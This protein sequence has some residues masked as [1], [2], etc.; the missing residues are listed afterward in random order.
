VNGVYT[1][2]N[3]EEIESV[4]W[5]IQVTDTDANYLP[6]FTSITYNVQEGSAINIPYKPAGDTAS[7]NITNIPSG[8]ANDGFNIVGTA[9][10]ITNGYGQAVQHVL[11]VTKANS[12][13]SV[14][15]T[16]TINVKANLAGN[17]FTLIDK[18]NGTIKFTQDGGATEL[19]FN[20][21]TFNA[22][23]TYKFYLDHYSIESSDGLSVVDSSGNILTG[24]EGLSNSGNSGDAGAY[25]QYVIPSNVAPGK[26][27]RYYDNDTSANYTDIP[28]TL[29]GST[30][31]ANPT[32]ITLEGPSANQTG[33]NVMDQY[34]HGWISLNETLA[35]GERLVLD[36]AFF[37]DFFGEFM[38]NN[39]IFAIGLKGD[40]WTNTKEVNN[41]TAAISGE[42]FKG[43]AYIIGVCTSGG[44]QVNMAIVANGQQGNTMVLNS[45][46]LRETTC[47]FLEVTGSGNNIRAAFGRN[48]SN[49]VTSGSESTVRYGDW[50]SYKGQT[51]EQG[52]GI[53]N[54]DV[55]MSFWT[56]DGGDIDGNE[57]DWTGLTEI[58][59]PAAPTSSSTNFTKA[60]DFSSSTSAY[61][62]FQGSDS[63]W[64]LLKLPA[65]TV[66]AHSSDA[67]L[68]SNASAA[69]PFLTSCVFQ[70]G[71][72]GPSDNYGDQSGGRIWWAGQGGSIAHHNIMLEQKGNDIFFSWGKVMA[73]WPN[74]TQENQIRVIENADPTKW[75]GV[76]IA[77]R[78]HRSSSPSAADLGAMFD[79]YVMS[80]DDSFAALGSN[81]ST[82]SEWGE[83][84]NETGH[85]ITGGMTSSGSFGFGGLG[86]SSSIYSFSGKI[87]SF[88]CHPLFINSAMPDATEIKKVIVDPLGWSGDMIGTSQVNYNRGGYTY[89][90]YNTTSGLSTQIYLFGDGTNDSFT[91]KIRNQANNLDTYY[92]PLVF[93]NMQASD[94]VNVT[95]NGL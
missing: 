53:T 62:D 37:T 92:T 87:A 24:N 84:W 55:V 61:L 33:G 46:S 36:N 95:I 28:M 27:L 77:H 45:A 14:Q 68:T 19:D 67:T 35:A 58:S 21:V 76:Y 2:P 59:I 80:S 26:F 50:N 42:F 54:L 60:V 44:G 11:N 43:N 34:D 71:T 41:A 75:Y 79:I 15:G 31:T 72:T 52:Y 9:E 47:A 23:Q 7:Y 1:A 3:G 29:A 16:I 82:A 91:N 65:R 74:R 6:T 88:V 22:G 30:Y 64:P 63:R 32:G 73:Q 20:T 69:E 8:Y 5:N 57:I 78:G 10:D 12:F 51:G 70:P 49:G 13:G 85:S 39:N 83:S 81:I 25:M 40:N 56:F 94:I 18:E 93:N 38:G 66:A 90:G 48:G 89:T 4:I 17:E 86:G